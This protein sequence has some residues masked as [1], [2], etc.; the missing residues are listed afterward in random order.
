MGNSLCN[1]NNSDLSKGMS[2]TTIPKRENTNIPNIVNYRNLKFE[3]NIQ[4][5]YE[6]K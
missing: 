2:N 6:F 4:S 1:I 5:R 3:E